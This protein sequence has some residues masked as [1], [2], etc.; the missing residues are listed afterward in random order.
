[1]ACVKCN[2]YWQCSPD[3]DPCSMGPSADSIET[4]ERCLHVFTKKAGGEC[5]MMVKADGNS[6][7]EG[8]EAAGQVCF[9]FDLFEDGDTG[10]CFV[11]VQPI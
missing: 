8:W 6:P 3:P 11:K 9:K 2:G 5:R 4:E 7:G 1:M 10:A